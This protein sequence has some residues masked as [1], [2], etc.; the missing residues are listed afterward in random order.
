[1]FWVRTKLSQRSKM[2][3][4]FLVLDNGMESHSHLIHHAV[5]SSAMSDRTA[6]YLRTIT[7]QT[8]KSAT[9]CRNTVAH[10]LP[11]LGAIV[12]LIFVLG[13]ECN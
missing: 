7:H 5:T 9:S 1:M 11:I 6:F 13:M 12:G 4:L 10:E 2:K 3:P 8:P